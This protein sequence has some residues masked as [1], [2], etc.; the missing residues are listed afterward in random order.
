MGCFVFFCN[1]NV[2]L[3]IVFSDKRKICRILCCHCCGNTFLAGNYPIGLINNLPSKDAIYRDYCEFW[4]L[5]F[6]IKVRLW[7]ERVDNP[8]DEKERYFMLSPDGRYI[9]Y[10]LIKEAD[11]KIYTEYNPIDSD[12][13]F[14]QKRYDKLMNWVLQEIGNGRKVSI[15]SNNRKTYFVKSF[16]NM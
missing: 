12:I 16:S 9:N 7:R 5:M 15:G 6:L 3:Q 2:S 8:S 1:K 10:G 13:S 11:D 14:S 4:E